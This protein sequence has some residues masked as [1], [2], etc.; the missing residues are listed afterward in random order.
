TGER[1]RVIPDFPGPLSCV[2]WPGKQPR[3]LFGGKTL[4]NHGLFVVDVPPGKGS[5]RRNLRISLERLLTIACSRD[6]SQA[7]LAGGLDDGTGCD[8]V[9]LD[10]DEEKERRTM[11]G[12]TKP[13]LAVAFIPGTK[14]AVSAG[15]D[16]QVIFWDLDTGKE[17]FRLDKEME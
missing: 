1:E 2:A 17:L 9:L 14:R 6:G 16:R 15:L 4:P 3:V 11:S 7:L 8:V 10:V 5:K 12:H 13:I